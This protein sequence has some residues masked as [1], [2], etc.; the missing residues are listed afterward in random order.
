[1]TSL[2][3]KTIEWAIEHLVR[4]SDTDIFPPAFEFQAINHSRDEVVKWLSKQ[5]ICQWKTRPFRRCLVP[6]QR[7]GFRLATQLDPLDMLF[8][9][10]LILEVGDEIEKARLPAKEKVS[11]SNRFALD[12]TDFLVFDR[13]TGYPEFQKH[14]EGLVKNHKFV[15]VADI[16][17]FYPRVYFHR[18]EGALSVAIRTLPTHIKAITLLI[19][20][21]NQNVSYGIPIGNNPSRLLA[22]VVIDD[23]DRILFSEDIV[24][25][26]YVD[27]YRIFCNSR[28]EAY[29]CLT[30]LANVL[31][32]TNGL[33]LQPQKTKILTAGE[34]VNGILETEERKEIGALAE[35]FEEILDQL[36]IDNPYGL[37]RRFP[38]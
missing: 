22:E 21:W 17:D 18:I 1:M 10:S 38:E 29:Q 35:G 6:K 4:H 8:Y 28:Q 23:V 36:G 11:F 5:D 34:F 7:Y 32:E 30:R 33:T 31:Y 16:A 26:R 9:L 37:I 13:T 25:T 27:D 24:F 2:S 19:K 3:P 12:N 20:G 14:S 15:V